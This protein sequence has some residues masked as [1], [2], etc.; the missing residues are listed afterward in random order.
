MRRAFSSLGGHAGVAFLRLLGCLP[1]TW[2]RGLGVALGLLLWALAVP[3]R[4]VVR[5]NL[6]LCFPAVSVAERRALERKVFI[7]FTQSWFD[8]GWLWHAPSAVLEQRLVVDGDVQFLQQCHQS[9]TPVVV[10]A[11][12]FVGLDAAWTALAQTFQHQLVTIYTPQ[13]NPVVDAWVARGRRRMGSVTL[14]WR[15]DGVKPVIKALKQ[16][17]W[18]YLLP[19]MNFGAQESVFVPFFGVQAA[20]VPSLSRFA[21]L[22]RAA[23]VPVQ[24]EMTPQG[25]RIHVLPAWHDMPTADSVAD[26]ALMNQRLEAM[27][28]RIPDQYYWVHKRFKSRP[29]GESAVY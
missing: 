8:R 27:I 14:T 13:R 16:G 10:F 5:L 17:Q 7:R 11:P 21:R 22:S 18:L 25:Y 28:R 12:H 29:E 24:V 20:T 4:R 19:D 6:A 15:N 1:L 9:G 26:T 2:L 3:R 23:V